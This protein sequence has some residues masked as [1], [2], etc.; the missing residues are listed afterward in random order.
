MK[1]FDFASAPGPSHAQGEAEAI[2]STIKL[3]V[4]GI[5]AAA[6]ECAG[7]GGVHDQGSPA[8]VGEDASSD[9]KSQGGVMEGN[10]ERSP[11]HGAHRPAISAAQN[12]R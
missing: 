3:F 2:G 5:R 7:A 11:A 4:T 12:P 6:N 10:R 8:A 1:W 9:T